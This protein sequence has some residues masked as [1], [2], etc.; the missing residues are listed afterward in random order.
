MQI[1]NMFGKDRG[2]PPLPAIQ[3]KK[4][5]KAMRKSMGKE[6]TPYFDPHAASVSFVTLDVLGQVVQR[7]C[8]TMLLPLKANPTDL[9][10]EL[11]WLQPD[12]VVSHVQ[13]EADWKVQKWMRPKDQQ[14]SSQAAVVAIDL[15]PADVSGV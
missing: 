9:G 10:E 15:T 12:S 11:A 5:L 1:A 7:F 13:T 8:A 2:Q 4:P 6:G 3:L 14:S